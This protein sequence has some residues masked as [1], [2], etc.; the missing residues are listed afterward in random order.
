[1]PI[2]TLAWSDFPPA[3]CRGGA[4]SVG[5]FD[6][7]HRGHQALMGRLAEVARKA[8][9]PA[10]ALTFDPHPL[11]V[12]RPGHTVPPL[13]TPAERDARLR[14]AGADRVLVLRTT[15][16]LLH[17]R[18][19]Q[20]FDEVIRKRLAARAM[21]EGVNFGFG[22]N[23]EG[24]LDT[25]AGLCA[26]AGLSLAVVPPVLLDGQPISSSRVRAALGRGAA[27]DAA[28]LLGRPYRIAGR[29]VT[30]QRRGQTL[31]FPTANLAEVA[32]LLPAEGV[33]A[34]RVA[35]G[36]GTWAGAAN[37]GPNPTF[38]ESARKIEV[39]LIGYAGDLVGRSLTVDFIDHLRDTRKFS[40]PEELVG[41][42]RQDVARAAELVGESGG[43]T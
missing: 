1:M 32:T 21:V 8:G 26:R 33:Y 29:V 43:G 24:N 36:D 6:G 39:H 31:G 35:T 4:V 9:G 27:R 16:D 42:L 19:E 20:F 3:D 30:G 14:A 15:A 5:N 10:V 11:E 37:L 18:A 22:R 17:L 13:T 41:Q 38:G 23:R 40:G 34:V 28:L 12:L 7:V 2:E 25:L